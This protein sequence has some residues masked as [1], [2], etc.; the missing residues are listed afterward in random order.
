M[1]AGQAAG[2]LLAMHAAYL[3]GSVQTVCNCFAGMRAHYR[4]EWWILDTG[5]RPVPDPGLTPF[6]E[7][8]SI[9]ALQILSP[10][11]HRLIALAIQQFFW[12]WIAFLIGPS[13]AWSHTDINLCEIYSL[14]TKFTLSYGVLLMHAPSN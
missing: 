2:W 1:P 6:L 8:L 14:L 9:P 4:I 5:T 12:L 7:F 13:L 11:N 10:V 3:S